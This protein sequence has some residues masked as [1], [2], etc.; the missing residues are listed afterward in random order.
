[1]ISAH[2]HHSTHTSHTGQCV[3]TKVHPILTVSSLA[4]E[5]SQEM[6]FF[7]FSEDGNLEAP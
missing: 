5:A 7:M 2:L 6:S 4:N 1:M 3:G